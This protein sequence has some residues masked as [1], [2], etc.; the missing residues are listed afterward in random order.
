MKKR[1]CA[2]HGTF[3]DLD[4]F[5]QAQKIAAFGDRYCKGYSND[6]TRAATQKAQPIIDDELM[7]SL[8]PMCK[9]TITD[10][11]YTPPVSRRAR[12]Y[13]EGQAQV[14][15]ANAADVARAGKKRARDQSHQPLAVDSD[16]DEVDG[17]AAARAEVPPYEAGDGASSTAALPLKKRKTRV[18]P[19]PA[20]TADEASAFM[21]ELS[22]NLYEYDNNNTDEYTLRDAKGSLFTF[23]DY[24]GSNADWQFALDDV[25]LARYE[26]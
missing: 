22:P 10:L 1:W 6:A 7:Y 12:T 2:Y 13:M 4:G 9:V 3:H 16:D 14:E 20:M 18:A 25:R 17:K 8:Q 23:D 24:E 26:P 5:S 11:E 19:P 21:L 15:A